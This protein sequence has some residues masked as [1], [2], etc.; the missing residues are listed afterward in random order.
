LNLCSIRS[1]V[2]STAASLPLLAAIPGDLAACCGWGWSGY[3]SYYAGYYG[4]GYYND[5]YS[6]C[7]GT[8]YGYSPAYTLAQS[9]PSG[10]ACVPCVGGGCDVTAPA[11]SSSSPARPVP[12]DRFRPLPDEP[13]AEAPRSRRR[14]PPTYDPRDAAPDANPG[15]GS[16]SAPRNEGLDSTRGRRRLEEPET[17]PESGAGDF[18]RPFGTKS[19]APDDR[20]PGGSKKEPTPKS[21]KKVPDPDDLFPP[22][23]AEETKT[24]RPDL[25][26]SS[27][28]IDATKPNST[29]VIPQRKPAPTIPIPAE[30][31]VPEADEPPS[32]LDRDND[33]T[34]TGVAPRTRL[35]IRGRFNTPSIV[36]LKLRPES[37]WLA[38]PQAPVLAK[39]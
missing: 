25:G 1:L 12:D 36:R 29:D 19:A 27:N 34:T 39:H 9:Y 30:E 32:A 2:W 8:S 11:P 3:G 17:T 21:D 4:G 28:S 24:N 20:V 35:A 6:G 14:T 23:D 38:A 16:S 31:A 18:Q 26:P 7:C 15:A 10:P 13:P 33:P 37:K 5:Y 22:D